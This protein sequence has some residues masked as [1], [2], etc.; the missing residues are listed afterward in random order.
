MGISEDLFGSSFYW[1]D[2][3]DLHSRSYTCGHCNHL[4]SSDKGLG[5]S[6]ASSGRNRDLNYRGLYIC[7]SCQGPTFFDPS[8]RQF[9]GVMIGEN[10]KHLP[11]D[12]D[13]LYKEAR[14]SFSVGSYTATVLLARKMLMNIAVNFGAKEDQSFVFYVDYLSQEGYIN[15][16]NKGWVDYIRRQGNLAT[17]KIEL[18]EAE[19]ASNILKFTE[20]LLKTNYEYPAYVAPPVSDTGPV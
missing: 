6:D 12:I 3:E 2:L 9:P 17:H 11:V 19:E 10:V 13:L 16:S 4:V 8:H 5:I 18:K 7:P 20:L 15:A 14:N 1:D